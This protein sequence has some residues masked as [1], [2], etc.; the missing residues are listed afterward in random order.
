[1]RQLSN[2]RSDYD[3]SHGKRK[4][5]VARAAR[6]ALELG[7]FRRRDSCMKVYDPMVPRERRHDVATLSIGVSQC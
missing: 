6:M 4:S 2:S 7:V 3:G 1:M 5:V